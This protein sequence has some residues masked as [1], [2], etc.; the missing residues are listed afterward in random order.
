MNVLVIMYNPIELFP[1]TINAI[2][3]LS[4]IC[5][6]ISVITHCINKKDVWPYPAN[7]EIKYVGDWKTS[8]SSFKNFIKFIKFTLAF[9]RVLRAGKNELIILYEPHAVL[10]Y[11]LALQVVKKKN[12]ILW[13]HNHDI[14]EIKSQGRFSIGWWAVKGERQ[15]FPKLDLF[16]LPA[17]ERCAYFPMKSLYGKFFFIPNYPSLHLYNKFYKQKDFS[18]NIKLIYQGRID[19]SHGIEEI[20]PLLADTIEHKSLSLH[21]KGFI[22]EAYKEKLIQLSIA[23]NAEEKVFFYGITSYKEVPRLTSDC[24]IGIGIHTKS[25]IMHKTLGTSSNK[26][27]EYI[28]LGLPVLLFDNVH[29]RT[30]LEKYP[31]AFFTD[32]TPNSLKQSLEIIIRKYPALSSSAY[33]DFT[34]DLNF[35]KKFK[36]AEKFAFELITT[37]TA[38]HH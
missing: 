6:K 4:K 34:E 36:E 7:V 3:S 15:I 8:G 23:H 22:T 1:P 38:Q 18:S 14:F 27:Y 5:K 29:F 17:M 35:E 25:E 13:Y 24:H 32:C 28:A 20:I 30:H 2:E 10:S 26:I 16:S 21:L 31:W 12:W 19:E 37:D 11:R 33:N 9:L